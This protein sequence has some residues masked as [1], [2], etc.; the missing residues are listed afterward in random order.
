M[1]NNIITSAA[2]LTCSLPPSDSHYCGWAA[3]V[4]L[5]GSCDCTDG[6]LCSLLFFP[7]INVAQYYFGGMV[8]RVIYS[9]PGQSPAG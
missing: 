4:L 9:L 2:N 7:G 8:K 3:I 5:K 1:G 6:S